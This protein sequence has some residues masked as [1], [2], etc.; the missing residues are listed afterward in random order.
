MAD[1]SGNLEPVRPNSEVVPY[2]HSTFEKGFIVGISAFAGLV[3]FLWGTG[4]QLLLTTHVSTVFASLCVLPFAIGSGF[5]ILR[6]DRTGWRPSPRAFLPVLVTLTLLILPFI[7]V[8]L[9]HLDGHPPDWHAAM[10]R[11]AFAVGAELLKIPIA[12]LLHFTGV[13]RIRA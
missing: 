7:S 6:A 10:Y 11:S 3:G 12:L 9:N 13:K 2:V 1:I 5:Y 8:G 4:V